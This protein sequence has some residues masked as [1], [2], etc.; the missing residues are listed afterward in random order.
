MKNYKI[1]LIQLAEDLPTPIES[2]T[3]LNNENNLK[4][5]FNKFKNVAI[6]YGIENNIDNKIYIGSS[7]NGSQRLRDHLISKT[8]NKSNIHLQN[9]IKKYSIS[10]FTLHIFSIL[11]FFPSS[12]WLSQGGV[13]LT[14]KNKKY[15]LLKEEQ[16]YI[17]IYLNL[18]LQNNNKILYNHLLKAGSSLGS[19]HK[20]KTRLKIS[21]SL[22]GRKS[23]LGNSVK[24]FIYYLLNSATANEAEQNI[25]L[26]NDKPFDNINLVAN[27]FNIS[28]TTV[29]RIL[30]KKFSILTNN[31]KVYYLSKFLLNEDQ[32][33]LITLQLI[34]NTKSSINKKLNSQAQEVW[35]YNT[36]KN[37][38]N[39]MWIPYNK[40]KPTFKSIR[41]ASLALCLSEQT[42]SYRIKV[43]KLFKLNSKADKD[44][45]YF[46]NKEQTN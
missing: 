13:E 15:L 14:I 40:D 28:R 11:N 42:I 27:Y 44:R 2:Y 1:D 30:N 46:F 36:Q 39:N 18:S 5:I 16:K 37:I 34:K 35:V 43:G 32:I 23:P 6:V 9:A 8:I 24:V 19:K 45:L 21:T 31:L 26:I 25:K 3:N 38:E 12:Y 4:N 10:N 17:D 22:L 29:V 7:I 20:L 41:K 33:K